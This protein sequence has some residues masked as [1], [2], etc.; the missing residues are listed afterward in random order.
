MPTDDRARRPLSRWLVP[1]ATFVV[2]AVMAIAFT[3]GQTAPPPAALS[4]PTFGADPQAQNSAAAGELALFRDINDKFVE[5]LRRYET[6]LREI[7]TTAEA[8]GAGTAAEDMRDFALETEI[9]IDRYDLIL[10]DR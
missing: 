4:V 6:R 8:E 1:A 2:G 10:K 5:Q 7:A 9:L 3:G